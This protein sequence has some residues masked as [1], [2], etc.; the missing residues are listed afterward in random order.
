MVREAFGQ[1][2]KDIAPTLAVATTP[3]VA[4]LAGIAV[5]TWLLYL[6]LMYAVLRLLAMVPGLYGCV[7][8]FYKN[9]TCPLTCKTKV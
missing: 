5:D 8:C 6:G 2:T 4:K 3:Q 9:K 1:A 7:C